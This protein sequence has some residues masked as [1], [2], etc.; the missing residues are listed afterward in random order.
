ML[1]AALALALLLPLTSCGGDDGN[2]QGTE[3]TVL[4][5]SSLTGAFEELANEF[6]DD[7]DGVN[8]TLSFGSSSTLAEQATQ[9]APGDVLATADEKSMT[10]AQDGDALS[11]DPAAFATNEMVL[12]VP[13]DNPA[14][15]RSLADLAGAD[16][17]RCVDDAPCG[18]VALALT[19]ANNLTAEPA[20]LEVDVK[21]V[22]AKVTSGEADAGFVYRTDAAA[23]GDE[24]KV[25]PV[26][27]SNQEL[28]TYYIA[29]LE[30]SGDEELAKDWIELV[31]SE[32]GRKVLSDAEFGA[33]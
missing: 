30:Q 32:A 28:T 19:E 17:V 24:V 1:R 29:P 4:A 14:D 18:R 25:I 7:H 11:A 16:F 21:A 22:L 31:Q 27:H 13:A 20:S 12:V 5:A 10:V 3:L 26:E 6:E 23:A 9:G 2:D 15:I 33:P 8:V